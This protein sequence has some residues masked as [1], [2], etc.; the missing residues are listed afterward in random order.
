MLIG[1]LLLLS[2]CTNTL[3]S[4]NI[5][6]PTSNTNASISE[7]IGYKNTEYG[8]SL[9]LPKDLTTSATTSYLLPDSWSALD[10]GT[11]SGTKLASFVMNGSNQIIASGIRIGA[12]KGSNEVRDCLSGPTYA[13]SVIRTQEI[14]GTTVKVIDLSDA[15]MNKYSIVSSYRVVKNNTCLVFDTFVFGSNAD[16]YENPP[17]PA[18][19][20]EEAF[21]KLKKVMETLKFE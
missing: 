7:D 10:G 16:V 18:F 4:P 12:S 21:V 15:A 14:N 20:K 6:A 3:P 19:T 9:S 17:Q 11:G 13:T 5:N 8:F 1:V 2:S